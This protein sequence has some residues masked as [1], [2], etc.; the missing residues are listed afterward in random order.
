MILFSAFFL[1]GISL[2]ILALLTLKQHGAIF[3]LI[4][5]HFAASCCIICAIHQLRKKFFS[6]TNS[7]MIM[8]FMFLFFVPI[9]GIIGSMILIRWLYTVQDWDTSQTIKKISIL[10]FLKPLRSEQGI[11]KVFN[12][13][14][15][16]Q[17]S[18]PI[19]IQALKILSTMS[20][21]KINILIRKVFSD[22]ESEL[23]LLAFNLIDTQEKKIFHKINTALSKLSHPI[24]KNKKAKIYRY[25]AF[26]YWDLVYRN[27]IDSIM[28]HIIL[29]K[30]IYY[31]QY[32]HTELKNDTSL[33][34]LLGRVYIKQEKYDLAILEFEKSLALSGHKSSTIL[35][36]AEAYFHIKKFAQVKFL[37]S[38][39]K[40][41]NLVD[42][43]EPVV[44]FWKKNDQT[45]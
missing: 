6:Y 2:E 45:N 24:T 34:N 14:F 29:E 28:L 43:N 15:S 30:I 1:I 41:I 19:R 26:E 23:R 11:S 35:Y 27:L 5:I 22:K 7:I 8:L 40:P 10:D 39:I 38:S 16:S 3:N 36:L 25:I 44:N 31:A 33:C 18:L 32:A 13:L 42:I 17:N 12:N 20:P 9:L 21:N 37:L 4:A